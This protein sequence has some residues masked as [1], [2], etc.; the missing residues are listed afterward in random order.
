MSPLQ[1][2]LGSATPGRCSAYGVAASAHWSWTEEY[3]RS[4]ATGAALPDTPTDCACQPHIDAEWTDCVA[5][6]DNSKTRAINAEPRNTTGA[7][8]K[9]NALS[10]NHAQGIARSTSERPPTMP[11]DMP[12]AGATS[13]QLTRPCEFKIC[14]DDGSAKLQAVPKR[15]RAKQQR[16]SKVIFAG[17]RTFP[18]RPLRR[19]WLP[20]SACSQVALQQVLLYCLAPR[21]VPWACQACWQ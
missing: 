14:G 17:L 10:V 7:F 4:E 16:A 5:A 20:P 1:R 12:N 18:N 2:I 13:E 3:A 8:F 19:S 11:R 6:P 21:Q 15:D 9:R